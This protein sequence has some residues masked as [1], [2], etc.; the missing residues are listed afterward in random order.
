[1]AVNGKVTQ[2][3]KNKNGLTGTETKLLDAIREFGSVKSAA[4]SVGLTA[5]Q[6]YNVL[7]KLRRRYIKYRLFTNFIDSGKKPHDRLRMV[8]V[9]RMVTRELREAE[10]EELKVAEFMQETA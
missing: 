6:A 5:R 9:N 4:V 1:M 10:A 2:E 7:Y 8:L 3:R